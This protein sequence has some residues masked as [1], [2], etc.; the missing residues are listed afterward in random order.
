MIGLFGRFERDLILDRTTEGRERAMAEGPS[1]G[2][3]GRDFKR[4]PSADPQ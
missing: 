3:S 4:S 2:P 1:H